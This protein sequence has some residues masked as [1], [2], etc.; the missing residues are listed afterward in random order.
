MN[1][2]HL[3]TDFALSASLEP[4]NHQIYRFLKKAIIEC[5]LMPD[6]PLSENEVSAK[7]K[8]RISRQPVR[9]ALI[10]L[11]ENNFVVIKPKKATKVARISKRDIIQ[12]SE[13]RKALESYIAAKAARGAEEEQLQM[14]EENVQTQ[15]LAAERYDLHA[16]FALDDEFHQI[17]CITAGMDKAWDIIEG[18]KGCMDRVRFLSLE[19]EITPI[20]VTSDAHERILKALRA[21]DPEGAEQ[22]MLSHIDEGTASLKSVITKCKPEWFID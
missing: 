7:F 20:G 16:H 11:A 17:I 12:G 22:A 10:K 15:R 5:R 2:S 19:Y 13:I 14:L 21:R 3:S 8:F 1:K 6:E 4:L 18:I 9:E